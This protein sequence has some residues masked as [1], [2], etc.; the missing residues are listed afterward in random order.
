MSQAGFVRF[1]RAVRDDPELLGRYDGRNLA[2]ALFHAKNDGFDFSA[3]DAEEVIARL[4]YDLVTERDGQPF[5]GASRLWHDMWGRRYL[6]YLV[7]HVV[8]RYPDAELAP[9][10]IGA[11]APEQAAEPPRARENAGA[12]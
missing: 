10:G 11:A 2:Q 7:E 4:E 6:G 9:V 5:D 8:R 3:A 1:L 12:T